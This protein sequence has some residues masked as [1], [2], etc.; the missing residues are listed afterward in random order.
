MTDKQTRVL[1]SKMLGALLREARLDSGKSITQ[2]AELLG[3]SASTLSSYEH[4]RKSF[5]LPELELLGYHLDIPL[6]RVLNPSADDLEEGHQFDP[7][8]MLALRQ[9]MIAAQLR[10]ARHDAGYSMRQLA[11]MIDMPVSRISAYERGL[12]SV[13][14]P[15]L[16]SLLDALD[17]TL[18]SLID[19]GGPV[20]AWLEEKLAFEH[21][22]ELPDDLRTFFSTPG[23]EPYL[24]MAVRLSQ[25]DLADLRAVSD[26]LQDLLP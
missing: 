23:H 10:Q 20:G 2:L 21:F 19:R 7:H 16:E 9:R 1:R 17:S 25:L 11:E 13:P 4:G 5:S 6:S 14:I 24:R 18:D 12:R 26:A 15:D 3:T 8:M 22:R